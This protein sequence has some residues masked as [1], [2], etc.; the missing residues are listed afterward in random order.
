MSPPHSCSPRILSVQVGSARA[1]TRPGSISA[2]V[3]E[4]VAGLVQLGFLGLEG[5][6]Q[7]DKRV[8]GGPDKAVHA[9]PLEH[10]TEWKCNFLK[11]HPLLNTSG[12]F[13]ENL[14]TEGL[15]EDTL[16]LG[17]RWRAGSALL[18]VSQGRQPC[19]KLDDRF[20]MKGLC[21]QV[22]S[23]RRT[24]WY[25]R[26]L[27]PGSLQAGDILTLEARPIPEW[28]IRRILDLLWGKTA[29]PF[30]LQAASELPLPESWLRVFRHR[31]EGTE[32]PKSPQRLDGPGGP[33]NRSHS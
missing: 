7:G 4:P 18:E 15:R 10:Y 33:S 32:D 3:K 19:W 30:D 1:F 27:E 21:R 2:I 12:A 17:D 20:Q 22:Q 5:D 13:G 31:L 29:K 14:T 16:F 11:G 6:E 26:V 8:H 23:T 9:Y 28:S 25:F 24:G